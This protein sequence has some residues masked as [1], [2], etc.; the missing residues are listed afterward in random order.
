MGS[1][2]STSWL[3]L[4]IG[5]LASCHTRP[6]AEKAAAHTSG[7]PR[8]Y[9]NAGQRAEPLAGKTQLV[10]VVTDGWDRFG[11]TLQ[12]YERSANGEWRPIGPAV[13]AVIGRE[14]YA[15][16]RG[17]HGE[18]AP[19]GAAGPL[20]REG[21]GRS[22]AG[23]FGIGPAY[24]YEASRPDISLPYFHASKELRCVDDP[25]SVHYNQIV[26]ESKAAVDW[27]SA[28]EMLRE[29][30]L[31]TLAIVVE[32]NTRPTVARAGSCI[33]LHLWKGPDEGMS[34]CTAV[35]MSA[36]EELAIWLKPGEAAIVA[37][38]RDEYEAFTERWALPR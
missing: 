31:Y 8:A 38:P 16:G 29:D 2:A 24:G 15:W 13:E 6:P 5:V 3:L 20:K 22:P 35:S 32:H 19:A 30:E 36:L 34:G 17:L 4:A 37:L 7:T 11:A 25:A 28:E 27:A 23:V 18:G 1:Q 9:A 21:D 12:R 10:S 33:F 14:G 26:S